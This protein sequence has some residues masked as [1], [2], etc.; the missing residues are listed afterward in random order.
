VEAVIFRLGSLETLF[1]HVLV[2]W[3][4]FKR[5]SDAGFGHG[6]ELGSLE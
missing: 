2:R 6:G 4:L 1:E 5:F 3:H